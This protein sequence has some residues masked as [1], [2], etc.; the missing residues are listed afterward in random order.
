MP[1]QRVVVSV[2]IMIIVLQQ[3]RKQNRKHNLYNPLFSPHLS[4]MPPTHWLFL[5]PRNSSGLRT[6]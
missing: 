6:A 1:L 4:I 5:A 2:V 3:N